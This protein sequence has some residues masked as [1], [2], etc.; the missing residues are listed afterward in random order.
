MKR[1]LYLFLVLLT[2]IITT[3][4]SFVNVSASDEITYSTVDEDLENFGISID[5]YPKNTDS[6]TLDFSVVLFVE[7][8]NDE[9]Y[10]YYYLYLYSPVGFALMGNDFSNKIKNIQIGYLS[11]NDEEKLND[12]A[13]ISRSLKYYDLKF[14]SSS[15]NGTV[16]KYLVNLDPEIKNNYRRYQLRK[17]YL[18]IPIVNPYYTLG[19]EYFYYDNSDGS[20]S[21]KYKKID[22]IIFENVKTGRFVVNDATWFEETFW[23]END[24]NLEAYF[25]GFSTD[26]KFDSL[27][28]IEFIYYIEDVTYCVEDLYDQP[29]ISIEYPGSPY[30]PIYSNE[31]YI[32]D[33]IDYNH[34]SF[35]GKDFGFMNFYESYSVD[36]DVISKYDD[37]VENSNDSFSNFI[38][39]NF[40]NC[41][42]IVNFYNDKFYFDKKNISA[43]SGKKYEDETVD[44]LCFTTG[45]DPDSL[46]YFLNGYSYYKVKGHSISDIEVVR[47]KISS[48]GVIYDL[49]VI[50]DPVG[51]GDKYQGEANESWFKQFWD[52]LCDF[53]EENLDVSSPL[54]EVIAVI[55]L[56]FI[57]FILV[58]IFKILI[59][60]LF[61]IK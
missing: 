41:D 61:N 26:E 7:S 17:I 58:Y 31:K 24:D 28:E 36:W 40:K 57:I 39:K 35:K 37:L 29:F 32:S 14:L 19:D 22:Y 56:I 54:T 18:D 6:T 16:S 38:S 51:P 23:A 21:Y 1:L 47:M 46:E 11:S 5:N 4:V 55:I 10:T 9:G 48:D 2:L 12:T 15:D 43:L 34:V 13:A 50:V 25:Y 27:V 33:V 44:F 52:A 20:V 53:I 3:P 60:K 8:T 49:D 45:R 59:D 30:N 42:Y